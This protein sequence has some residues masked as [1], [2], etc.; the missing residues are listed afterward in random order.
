MAIEWLSF[1]VLVLCGGIILEIAQLRLRLPRLLLWFIRPWTLWAGMNLI[2]RWQWD[3]RFNNPVTFPFYGNPWVKNESWSEAIARF[4]DHG[5]FGIWFLVLLLVSALACYAARKCADAQPRRWLLAALLVLGFLLPVVFTL[6]PHGVDNIYEN[7]QGPLAPWF[8]AG[9]TMLFCMPFAKT[10][11]LYL[12]DFEN[13]QPRLKISVH[14]I[15]HPPLASLSLR[16]IGFLTGA[17]GLWGTLTTDRLRYAIAL[18]LFSSL[19]ILAVY[20][21]AMA[22]F[23]DRRSALIAAALWMAKPAAL[24]HNTFAQDGVYTVFFVLALVLTWHVVT[25]ER[26]RWIINLALG[27]CFAIITQLTFSWCIVTSIFAVFAVIEGRRRNWPRRDWALR[28][29]L[30]LVVMTAVSAAFCLYYGFDYFEI[31]QTAS[32]FV[33][34]FYEFEN[35]YQW[36]MALFGGQ[37]AILLM[38]GTLV[39][40]WF[41][42]EILPRWLKTK[43]NSAS[44]FGLSV[45][46]IY[47]IPLLLGPACLK[48]ETDRCWSW[49]TAI[50][51]VFVAHALASRVDAS[52]LVPLIIAT[53]LAQYLAMRLFVSILS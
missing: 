19:G 13:I 46:G 10:S 50:P 47:F 16:W 4:A 15:S 25:A 49:V 17:K 1:P 20:A 22:L 38:M 42:V 45:L 18:T 30:P 33:D 52:R 7:T 41:V 21:L 23:S 29:G 53:N 43:L 8:E 12:R 9:G 51:L 37:L 2:F 5:T 34:G 39:G 27:F 26:P 32:E 24:S 6:V 28:L 3:H 40:S 11:E 36:F 48:M 14:G 31:Y 44:R 35:G